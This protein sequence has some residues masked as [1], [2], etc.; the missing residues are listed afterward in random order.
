M[1]GVR[2]FSPTPRPVA[3]AVALAFTV[4]AALF[5]PAARADHV[6]ELAQVAGVR[7]NQLIG[8]GIV[9]G[10]AILYLPDKDLKELEKL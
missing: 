9:I 10:L 2:L 4:I 1:N 5:S 3:V 8:Y 6:R 7:D